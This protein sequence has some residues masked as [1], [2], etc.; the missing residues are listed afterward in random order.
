ME[1]GYSVKKIEQKTEPHLNE[2]HCL[3]LLITWVSINIDINRETLN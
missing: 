3:L 2:K 1:T